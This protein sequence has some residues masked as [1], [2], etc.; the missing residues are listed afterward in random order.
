MPAPVLAPRGRAGLRVN[1]HL[2][3]VT[4]QVVT[5]NLRSVVLE[6]RG[7]QIRFHPRYPAGPLS[8]GRHQLTRGGL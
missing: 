5:D 3:G 7:E 2:A 1:D 8:S 6:R 4:R